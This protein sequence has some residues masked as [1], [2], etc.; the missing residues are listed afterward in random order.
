[1]LT[2]IDLA[3]PIQRKMI[4]VLANQ[5][6]RQQPWPGYARAIGRLG[7]S[8]CTCS[9]TSCSSAWCARANHYE[10]GGHVLQHL[11][12]IFA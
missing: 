2:R 7:A 12:D 5:N 1:M 9:R 6:M 10:T 11:G 3:L 8:A 4:A